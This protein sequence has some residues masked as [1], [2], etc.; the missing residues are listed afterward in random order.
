M[1]NLRLFGILV[2]CFLVGMFE[3]NAKKITADYTL[4]E[5]LNEQL[6]VRGE[7]VVLNMNGHKIVDS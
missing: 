1:K 2:V 3:V 4:E 6:V 5:D 7:N